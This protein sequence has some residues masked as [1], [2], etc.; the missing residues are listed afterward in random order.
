VYGI[1]EHPG[2]TTQV[3]R[4]AGEKNRYCSNHDTTRKRRTR[5][6]ENQVANFLRDAGF[7]WSAWNKQLSETGCGTYRPD[8]TFEADTHVVIIEV[9]EHQ[10]ASPG[11]ACDNRRM[12]DVFNA[13]GG[14][15]VVFLRWNPDAFKL[16]GQMERRSVKS[17][18]TF[19]R[20][21]LRIALAETPKHLL[22]I[23]RMF[24]DQPERV[25]V[26]STYANPDDAMF[27][28]CIIM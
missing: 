8:F 15:P 4:A 28:E 26:V 21:Q 13:Y 23:K 3:F 9:D 10:H 6:R 17:R 20:E 1:C 25:Y 2:C 12:L 16:R 22:S 18:L 11:Y 24:Y 7:H 27:T 19:L 5:V 14:L